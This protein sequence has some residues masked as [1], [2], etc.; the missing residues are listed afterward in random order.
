MSGSGQEA[1]FRFHKEA[2][3]GQPGE[4]VLM[5]REKLMTVSITSIASGI[6]MA[7]CIYEEVRSGQSI[8]WRRYW[9]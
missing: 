3:N 6:N 8:Q 5:H 7:S 9:Q 2:G 1:M 4:R